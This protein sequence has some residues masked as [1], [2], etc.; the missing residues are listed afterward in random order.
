MYVPQ[1][2]VDGD[3]SE[4]DHGESGIIKPNGN[5]Y[6]QVDLSG[7]NDPGFVKQREYS[8]IYAKTGVGRLVKSTE[9]LQDV[10]M[11][12]YTDESGET[13]IGYVYNLLYAVVTVGE[14]K[15]PSIA[16]MNGFT[17]ITPGKIRAYIFSSPDGESYLDLKNSK[18]KLGNDLMFANGSLTLSGGLLAGLVAVAKTTEE[19]TTDSEGNETTSTKTTLASFNGKEYTLTDSEHGNIMVFAGANDDPQNSNTI[20]Y[21]DGLLRA[22]NVVLEGRIVAT[23]G[24]IAGFEINRHI[25]PFGYYDLQSQT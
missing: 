5:L 1:D 3:D 6:F 12:H 8:G 17:E 24:T 25:E 19:T 4:I 23:S 22:N 15:I 10:N 16:T 11:V 2:K 18:F 9:T 14:N 13:V 20:I 7:E 21:E